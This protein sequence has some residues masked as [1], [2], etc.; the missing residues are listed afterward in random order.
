MPVFSRLRL[1]FSRLCIGIAGALS[2][3][4]LLWG[5]V[6]ALAAGSLLDTIHAH[7]VIRIGTT[8]D[9]APYSFRDL[10]T[11]GFK[12]F[13]IEVARRLA[14]DMGVKLELV[15]ATWPTLMAGLQAGKYDL[16][17]SGVTVTPER[18]EAAQF[19][20]PYLH[21]RFVPIVRRRDL[22]R[23]KTLADIDQPSVRVALQQGTAAEQAG[24]RV[25]TKATLKAVLEPVID[26]TEVL[27]GHADATFTDNLYFAS[28]IGTQY[29]ELAMIAGDND[30]TSDIA[31]MTVQ[32]DPKLAEWLN[33]WVA[34]RDADHFFDGLFATW[35][36][37]AG[38]R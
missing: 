6:P 30:A 9:Y 32:G 27:A 1:V 19:S 22:G 5:V 37:G 11:G 21:P 33:D 2:V 31:L 4:A 36:N 15:Q 16:V 13:D 34:A 8:G 10:D 24:R 35:F 38:K 18:A 3:A 7:G 17:A 12:G 28:T 23:F 14:A 29:P 25:F 20:T 26:Y